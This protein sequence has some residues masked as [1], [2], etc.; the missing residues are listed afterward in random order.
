MVKR[1]KNRNI[2]L[3]DQSKGFDYQIHTISDKVHPNVQGAEL[4]AQVWFKALLK[5]LKNN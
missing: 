4:M 3:V 5:L 2:Y 1:L